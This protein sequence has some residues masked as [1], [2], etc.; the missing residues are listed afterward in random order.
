MGV[1]LKLAKNITLEWYVWRAL[2]LKQKREG[3]N[4]SSIVNSLLEV[5]LKNEISDAKLVATVEDHD[6]REDRTKENTFTITDREKE[7]T[8]TITD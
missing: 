8:F 5:A 4:I 7:D 2:D 1:T 3:G 6:W